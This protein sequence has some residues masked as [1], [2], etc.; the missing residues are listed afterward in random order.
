MP[1][2]ARF[3]FEFSTLTARFLAPDFLFLAWDKAEMTPSY[4]VEKTDWP[5]L[6]PVLDRND[7][8]WFLQSSAIKLSVSND[9]FLLFY[10]SADCLVRREEPPLK[11]GP[12]WQ[13]K[14][15]LPP[16]ACIYGLGERAAGLNLRP[17]K[18]RLLEP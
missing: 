5:I 13:H 17:G 7:D 3:E 6:N 18:Y 8:G 1:G 4:G 10:D 14:A 16:E 9:G 2:G 12:A 15:T 11:Y